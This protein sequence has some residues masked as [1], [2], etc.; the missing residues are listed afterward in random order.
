MKTL[1]AISL[2]AAS[3]VVVLTSVGPA[4]AI[5]IPNGLLRLELFRCPENQAIICEFAPVSD[6]FVGTIRV[7]RQLANSVGDFFSF[8]GHSCW[9]TS[10]MNLVVLS[11][12]NAQADTSVSVPRW[13]VRRGTGVGER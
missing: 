2:L 12:K 5:P 10:A 8:D 9:S 6:P 11:H 1:S 7:T 4:K 3:L 13:P